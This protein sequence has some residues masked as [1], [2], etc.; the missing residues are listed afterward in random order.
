MVRALL[1]EEGLRSAEIR[2]IV[3]EQFLDSLTLV[4]FICPK[5]FQ[6]LGG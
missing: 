5:R 4:S 1:I 6:P 3:C 2:K